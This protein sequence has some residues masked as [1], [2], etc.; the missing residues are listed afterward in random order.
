MPEK[1][2]CES[3]FS[4]SPSDLENTKN[5]SFSTEEKAETRKVEDT[6]NHEDKTNRASVGS[7]SV[8][9]SRT[10]E[11]DLAYSGSRSS[12]ESCNLPPNDTSQEIF[13][14]PKIDSEL[15]VV[16]DLEKGQL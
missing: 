11:S 4:A 3:P 6:P 16:D 15:G 12:L 14:T 9:S 10:T 5:C 13:A 1:V 2:S 7:G 8:I